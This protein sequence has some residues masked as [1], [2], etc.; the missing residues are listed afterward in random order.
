MRRCL[1]AFMMI[2]APAVDGRAEFSIHSARIAEGDLWVVGQVNEPD[3]AV[4]LDDSFTERTDSRGRFRFRL[5]Y[6]PAL[7]TVVLK[8]PTQSRVVVIGNCGQRGAQGPPG[9][10]G[11]PGAPGQE[12]R[13]DVSGTGT[14]KEDVDCGSQSALYSGEDGFQTWVTRKGEIEA[15]NPLRPLSGGRLIVLQVLIRGNVATAYGPDFARML[16]GGPPDRIQELHGAPIKWAA[17]NNA[18]PGTIHIV[19]EDSPDVL[20]RLRF[21]ECGAPPKAQTTPT[22]KP[23]A[24]K[25]SSVPA[26]GT[27]ERPRNMPLPS[28]AL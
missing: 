1:A 27:M 18:L 2:V 12:S 14:I 26:P 28:G 17:T 3:V 19:A 8:T 23:P 25:P 9:E 20:A 16:R 5:A 7:C 13:P 11:P 24:P 10:P 15:K 4:T 21:K 6:H 22:G